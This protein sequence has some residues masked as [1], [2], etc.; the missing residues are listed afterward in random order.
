M[1]DKEMETLSPR[2]A[3]RGT[4]RT[5]RQVL[6]AIEHAKAVNSENTILPIVYYV[7]LNRFGAE[8][9]FNLVNMLGKEPKFYKAR[10]E[11]LVDGVRVIFKS[12][13]DR[14]FDSMRGS[15]APIYIDHS[16]HEHGW[17]SEATRQEFYG[18][19]L[20]RIVNP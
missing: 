20:S 9:V 3:D 19:F 12:A 13:H 5:T 15:R 14:G 18:N 17:G 8:Q 11:M 16:V 6:A 1:K 2:D 4:G 10:G 7:N